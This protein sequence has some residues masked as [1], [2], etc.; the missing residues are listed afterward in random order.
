MEEI[1]KRIPM[2]VAEVQQALGLESIIASGDEL[3]GYSETSLP[4]PNIPPGAVAFPA[5]TEDVKTLVRMANKY[6]TPLTPM[7][8][9][10]NIG[11]GVRLL[12][13]GK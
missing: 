9:G 6:R 12:S 8:M 3:A 4:G 7:S 11:R 5:S 2:F 1:S 10:Q 13:R